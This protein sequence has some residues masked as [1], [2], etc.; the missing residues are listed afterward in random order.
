MQVIL[1]KLEILEMRYKSDEELAAELERLADK[2]MFTS[3]INRKIGRL[4]RELTR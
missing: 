4:A 2:V 3:D 1:S